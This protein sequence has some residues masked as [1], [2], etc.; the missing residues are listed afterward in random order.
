M[1]AAASAGRRDER[2]ARS[3]SASG[4][5]PFAS[6]SRERAEAAQVHGRVADEVEEDRLG[7]N[8]RRRGERRQQVAGVGHRRVGQHPLHVGLRQRPQ[9]AEHHAERRQDRDAGRQ[10]SLEAGRAEPKTRSS[11]PKAATFTPAAMNAVT[12]VGAPS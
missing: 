3:S 11:A 10:S 6:Q 9:V 4:S 8:A 1:S 5:R 7:R 12:V 2:P